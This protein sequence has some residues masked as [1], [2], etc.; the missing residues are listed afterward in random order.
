MQ[1]VH[2]LTPINTSLCP[3][4]GEV[5]G[6]DKKVKERKSRVSPALGSL[7]EVKGLVPSFLPSVGTKNYKLPADILHS[8]SS[9]YCDGC[10]CCFPPANRYVLVFTQYLVSFVTQT[11]KL[12]F[13]VLSGCEEN[14]RSA[15]AFPPGC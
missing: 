6:A 10:C 1:G 13:S 11:D 12:P 14:L 3:L 7:N 4:N 5:S 2:Q 8:V 15:S 9:D